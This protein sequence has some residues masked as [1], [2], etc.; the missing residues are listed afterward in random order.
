VVL[1]G[2]ATNL[3]TGNINL[4]DADPA[5]TKHYLA[6]DGI[7]HVGLVDN[8]GNSKDIAGAI[9][10]TEFLLAQ[11]RMVDTTAGKYFFWGFPLDPMDLI[12]CMDFETYIRVTDL[13]ETTTVDKMGPQ[14]TILTGQLASINGHPIIVSPAMSKTEADGKVSTTGSN[15]T[16]GQIATYNRRGFVV[17]WRR[18]VQI[19]TERLPATDQTRIVASLR[20]GFG[21]FGHAVANI[22]SA[23]VMRNIT[24]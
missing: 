7:R 10:R 5:D 23:D 9:S 15:N 11:G 3:A 24:V 12:H 22:E 16:K 2:D 1:N 19:E 21:R 14:A 4:D 20:L 17:G 8:T 6:F 13:N 18:R